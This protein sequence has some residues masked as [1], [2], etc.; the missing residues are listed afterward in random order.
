MI[1]EKKVEVDEYIKAG[2]DSVLHSA[3]NLLINGVVTLA[4][5]YKIPVN[6]LWF[7]VEN[8]RF[9]AE[10]KQRE[11][12]LGFVV[13]P[14]NPS[15]EKYLIELLMPSNNKKSQEL[16]QDLKKYGQIEPGIITADGFTIDGNRRLAA[17]KLLYAQNSNGKFFTILVHRLPA[18]LPPSQIYKLEVQTQIKDPLKLKYNPINDL[19]KVKDGLNYYTETE[20]AD[21]LGWKPRKV[22]EYKDRLGLVD[23]FLESINSVGDYYLLVNYNEHFIEFQKQLKK[24][25]KELDPI[26]MDEVF[27]IFNY[28]M[29]INIE[30]KDKEMRLTQR[31]HIR[32]IAAA[33]IDKTIRPRLIEH[34]NAEDPTK[35]TAIFEDI[36]AATQIAKEKINRISPI[37][38]V[39]RAID[40]LNQIPLTEDLATN[41]A[42]KNE[43]NELEDLYILLK[44]KVEGNGDDPSNL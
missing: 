33:Y 9:S 27:D 28:A 36:K 42:F 40:Y 7:N 31:D 17:L 3:K 35:E 38:L 32:Y 23:E 13:D 12:K 11:K 37:Q 41:E 39:K 19:L 4:P 5:V 43:F 10:K 2:G 21:I 1:L 29:K 24:V 44:E 15:H 6:M 16:I 8:G 20:L 26:E 25:R 22:K 34:L 14:T 18:N 30:R